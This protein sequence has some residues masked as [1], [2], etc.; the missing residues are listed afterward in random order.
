M[1]LF[2]LCLSIGILASFLVV[3]LRM[4]LAYSLP[5]RS[6]IP[7]YH[8]YRTLQCLLGLFYQHL[9]HNMF[10]HLLLPVQLAPGP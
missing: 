4:F 9:L 10:V 5:L 6:W 8:M 2:L 7:I 3:L 1:L